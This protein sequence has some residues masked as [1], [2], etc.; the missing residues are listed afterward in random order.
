MK[1][2]LQLKHAYLIL[3]EYS[4]I[5]ENIKKEQIHNHLEKKVHFYETS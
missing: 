1:N 2:S 5:S 4:F 3:F